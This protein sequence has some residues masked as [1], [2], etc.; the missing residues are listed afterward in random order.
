M[1]WAG[2]LKMAQKEPDRTAAQSTAMEALQALGRGFDVTLDLRLAYCKGQG[3]RLVELTEETYP[4]IVIPGGVRIPNVSKD[5]K[6]DKG[7]RTHFRSEVLPFHQMSERFNQGLSITGKMPLGLFNSMYSFNGTWQADASATKALALDGWF[8]TL[9]N[10]QIMKTTLSLKEEVK[11]AVP[12]F[13]EPA[14][15]ARF[16]ERYGTHVIVSVKIGGK[17]VVY[18]KQHQS[19]TL[20]SGE[21]QKYLKKIADQRFVGEGSG[22]NVLEKSSDPPTST[23]HAHR[24]QLASTYTSSS[25][26]AKE[27][28]EVIFRRRGGDN[29]VKHHNDWLA[30][31]SSAPD[32]ISMSFVPI[33]SFLNGVPGSGFLSQA[34]NLY[35]RYKPPIE[36]L[37]FFLEFQIP[38]QWSPGFDLPLGPQRKEPVC[39]AMQFSLM[40]PKLYVSTTQVTVGRRPVTGL[41]L[42]LEGKKCN[43]LA[44]HLQHLSNLPKI[45]QP[46]WDRHVSIGPPIWKEPEEQD[47]KW[48]EPVQWKSFSH[49]STAPVEYL[50]ESYVGDANAAYIV[51]G[52]QLRV[53]DFG[54]K[55]VLFLRLLFSMVP[56]CSI[57]KTVW[58]HTPQ[59]SQKSGLFSQLGL[60]S[61]FT[62]AA[63]KAKPA[64]IVLNSAVFPGGPPVPMQSPK[65]LKFVDIKEM[66]KGAQDMPGHWLVTGAKLD[67]DKGKIALRVK[68]SLLHY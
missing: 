43:R 9:Y 2:D 8:I 47:S 40:G 42:F 13:W 51:T 33:T 16:I 68:Y 34:V 35:L 22:Q 58:D 59:T 3:S 6:C 45:L 54:M 65:L 50:L 66:T 49:V 24:L 7:E 38:R 23:N 52:A 63:Q 26:T 17:D 19:S 25:F 11:K 61:T 46:H 28:V 53:W 57:K 37:Q 60:S 56:G 62:S 41:R 39:P 44:I 36:E 67:V 30:T 48:F 5:I 4:D 10:M 32:V 18:I 29:L 20:S 12:S 31:V 27:E 64:P 55:N 21:I 1:V 15:M 14:A